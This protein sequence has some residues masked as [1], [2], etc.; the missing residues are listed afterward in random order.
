MTRRGGMVIIVDD[1]PA[2]R[3]SLQTLFS[4]AGFATR[5][6]E[7]AKSL[8]DA[9]LPAEPVCVLLD[10][11][12]TGESGIQIQQSLR[13]I[14]P[15]LPIIFL[16]GE[17]D[18]PSAV[19]ALKDG[20]LDFFEKGAFRPEEL[21]SRVE[22]ALYRHRQHLASCQFQQNLTSKI[23]ALS[24]R[25]R[26]VASLVAWGKANKAIAM[27]LGISERTVEIHRSSV[28]RKLGLR[29]VTDLARLAKELDVGEQ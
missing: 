3:H 23:K 13:T 18:V 15:A 11:R 6:H 10:L 7:D 9:G 20:A 16:S 25:E 29:S 4:A 26:E 8:F 1:D 12:L 2:V 14:D 5:G 17:A 21:L 19:M 27:E 24:F 28:M 22:A